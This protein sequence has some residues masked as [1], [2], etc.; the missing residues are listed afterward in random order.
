MGISILLLFYDFRFFLF[1]P[2]SATPAKSCPET[3]HHLREQF[4]ERVDKN[5]VLLEDTLFKSPSAAACVVTYTSANGL[6]MWATADGKT[7]KDIESKDFYC[8]TITQLKILKTETSDPRKSPGI[9]YFKPFQGEIKPPTDKI[10]FINWWFYFWRRRWDSNPRARE[11]K[12]ISSRS[13]Y[14]HFDTSPK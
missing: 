2:V 9:A 14:D 8:S 10:L 7:L 13:R 11:D 3:I 4:A 1:L 6:I 12:T 5:N